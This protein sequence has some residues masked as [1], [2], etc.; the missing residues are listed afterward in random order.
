[1]IALGTSSWLFDAWR[2]PFYPAEMTRKE[3]L[4]YYARHFRTVEVN[5]SFYGQPRASTIRNW[6]ATVPPDFTFC[7]KFPRVISHEKR[8]VDCETESVA[9]IDLLRMLD[10]AA[11]P[12]FLQLPPS[13]TRANAGRALADYLAWLANTAPDL[14]L[15][16][17][18]RA[19]DLL[20]PA[21]LRY[22]MELDLAPVLVDR[23]NTPD[24]FP[25]WL[26]LAEQGVGPKYVVLR[27]IGDDKNGPTG[28]RELTAPREAE[29]DQW[30]AR[31]V[32]VDGMGYDLF[33]YM[34]N[35]YEG[36]A[37]ASV[38]RLE[39][40]LA[41]QI[42]LPPWAPPPEALEDENQLSLFDDI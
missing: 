16:V 29:L 31:L 7:L 18:V 15:A 17:E 41:E 20:T 6:R 3:Y 5:T 19:A 34:H 14:R 25:A 30:S 39:Q 4:A 21:F 11:A 10:E 12:A 22:V 1:M 8:L 13:L 23:V 32:A 42:V 24:L 2:G 9:F 40:R 36:H 38:R 37:P 27:W 35:P 26:E 28:D 33:G